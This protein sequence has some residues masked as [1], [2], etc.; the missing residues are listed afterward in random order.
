MPSA[1]IPSFSVI[2][3]MSRG[4]FILN[5]KTPF[6]FVA[7]EPSFSLDGRPGVSHELSANLL[8]RSLEDVV[9]SFVKLC[10]SVFEPIFSTSTDTYTV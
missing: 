1:T 10:E 6:V 7:R 5:S 2:A 9:P 8:A 4:I 3:P